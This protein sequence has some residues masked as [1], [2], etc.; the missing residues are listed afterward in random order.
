MSVLVKYI[1]TTAEIERTEELNKERKKNERCIYT[2]THT[3][4]YR[5]KNEFQNV[6]RQT[7]V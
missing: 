3:R 1:A 2:H 5:V 4:Y 6:M 7:F